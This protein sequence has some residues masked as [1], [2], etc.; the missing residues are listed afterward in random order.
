MA[1]S[2]PPYE[3]LTQ[4]K[5]Y[6]ISGISNQNSDKNNGCN[7]SKSNN[8]NGKYSFTKF[9]NPK[10][11]RKDIKFQGVGIQDIV[12]ESVPHP[13]KVITFLTSP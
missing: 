10:R 11:D 5:A 3:A 2:H 1:S 4:Q 7:S 13:G 12:R 9:Q 6:L 8:R